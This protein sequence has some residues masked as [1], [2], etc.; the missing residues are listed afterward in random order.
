MSDTEESYTEEYNNSPKS[1][2]IQENKKCIKCK[3]I[4]L[5]IYTNNKNICI[6]CTNNTINFIMYCHIC[7]NLFEEDNVKIC[8]ECKNETG[9]CCGALYFCQSTTCICKK[10]Y[11]YECKICN[12]QTLSK[13]KQYCEDIDINDK[14]SEVCNKCRK[15]YII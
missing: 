9:D 3:E 13:K 5:C 10:C 15:H 7:N 2:V 14:Y 4:K 12:K 1:D 6:K 8:S 11:K